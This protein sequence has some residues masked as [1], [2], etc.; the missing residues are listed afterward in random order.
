VS[1]EPV[2]VTGVPFA[3]LVGKR[4][5]P[6]VEFLIGYITSVPDKLGK[7]CLEIEQFLVRQPSAGKFLVNHLLSVPKTRLF[8]MSLK[9]YRFYLF[10]T[11]VEVLWQ[12]NNNANRL[13]ESQPQRADD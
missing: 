2:A 6:V 11:L 1:A 4:S 3:A 13:H 10:G 5:T 8:S 9:P 12:K 7:Y